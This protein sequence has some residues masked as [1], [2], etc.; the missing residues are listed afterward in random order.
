MKNKIIIPQ[1]GESINEVTLARFLK[2]SGSYVEENEEIA[3]IE[4]EK[5]NQ[6]LNASGS[7]QL[8]W[9]VNEG[10]KCAIGQEVA[11]IEAAEK[12][13]TASIE[14]KPISPE[15]TKIEQKD[16]K[17]SLKP[18][19]PTPSNLGALRLD[20]DTF[21]Q[22]PLE[23]D[24]PPKPK[25]LQKPQGVEMSPIRKTIARRLVQSLHESA[26]LT[27][28]NEVDMTAILSA[29][30]KHGEAFLKTYGVKL[31]LLSFFVKAITHAIEKYPQFNSYIKDEKI[32]QRDSIDVG[33]A[34]ATDKGLIVPVIRKANTLSLHE[35]ESQIA[36]LAEKARKGKIAIEDIEGGS[37]TLT[38]GGVFGSLLSTPILNPPQVGIL[39]MHKIQDRPVA[40]DGKVV[41]SP[42]MYLAL[43]YDHRM[44][45]GKEAVGFLVEVKACLEDI[46][47]T[48]F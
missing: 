34:V 6:L 32:Y 40:V 24:E 21:L 20:V 38:N 33:V 46:T 10:D 45:D 27:T 5:A 29:R 14:Q 35:I 41:I 18:M 48:L 47:V 12:P 22:A 26:M 4:T 25:L 28:F 13:V 8:V 15:K 9:M 37:F 1:L 42:M 39:G 3:E 2:P 31:G 16:S 36:A 43:S 23:K 17:E 11:V 7:G 44:I 30:K 19:P